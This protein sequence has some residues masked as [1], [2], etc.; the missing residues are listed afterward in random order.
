M[1]SSRTINSINFMFLI[2]LDKVVKKIFLSSSAM[3]NNIIVT[4]RAN[5]IGPGERTLPEYNKSEIIVLGRYTK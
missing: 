2:C 4:I 1:A 3:Y 5:V